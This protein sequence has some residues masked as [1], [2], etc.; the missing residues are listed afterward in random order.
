MGIDDN[1]FDL[2]GNSLLLFRLAQR[3][4]E[5]GSTASAVDLFRYPTVRA[6][7][8]FVAEATAEAPPAPAPPSAAAPGAERARDGQNR[9]AML[10]GLKRA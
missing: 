10:R 2:G 6:Q 3:L 8:A 1:F 5:V 4:R 9:L 7:A